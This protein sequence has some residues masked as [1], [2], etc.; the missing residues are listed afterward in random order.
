MPIY[1]IYLSPSNQTSN[2]GVNGY[3]EAIEMHK[4]A[5]RIK[6]HLCLSPMFNVRISDVKWDLEYVRKDSV[7]WGSSFHFCIH[8]D[9]GPE[10]AQGTTIFIYGTGGQ[11]EKFANILYPRISKLSP[12]KDRGIV[13][14]PGLYELK[15]PGIPAALI[16]NIF[17]TNLEETKHFRNNF[18]EYARQTALAFYEFYEVPYPDPAPEK[19]SWTDI[20]DK[21][22]DKPDEWIKAVDTVVRMAQDKSNYGDLEIL[23][24]LPEL[25]VK[26]YN[27]AK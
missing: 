17:H 2:V 5:E 6:Y 13:V 23:K 25:I 22:S 21:Y 16:E 1:K 8:T 12:G 27:N 3:N 19:L 24:Y 4:L 15:I 20:I 11:G 9:A 14:R 18:E 26:I 7:N 10:D